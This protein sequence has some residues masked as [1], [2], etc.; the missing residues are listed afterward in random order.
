MK[1]STEVFRALANQEISP[2]QARTLVVAIKDHGANIIIG[3]LNERLARLENT[4][5]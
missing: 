1:M 3:D 4:V 2:A 5:N